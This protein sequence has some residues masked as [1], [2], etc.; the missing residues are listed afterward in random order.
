MAKAANILPTKGIEVVLDGKKRYLK[1]TMYSL[2]WLADRHGNVNNVLKIFSSMQSGEM[3]AHD[4]HALADLVCA[5]LQYDDKEITPE[6]IEQSLDVADILEILPK[7]V[8]AFI[9]SM[10]TAKKKNP[11][12]A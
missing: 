7:I 10:W 3:S 9:V 6:Q 2:A 12:K 5:A 8:D 1:F 11:P 4:L